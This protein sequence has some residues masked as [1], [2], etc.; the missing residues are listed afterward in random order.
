MELATQ[1]SGS[2]EPVPTNIARLPISFFEKNYIV[3]LGCRQNPPVLVVVVCQDFRSANSDILSVYANMPIEK[4]VV[5]KEE[6]EDSLSAFKEEQGRE[7]VIG[8]VEGLG[9]ENI[10]EITQEIPNGHDLQ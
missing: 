9:Q 4:R 1:E 10:S 5:S 2:L 7:V 6:F 8:V 3:P